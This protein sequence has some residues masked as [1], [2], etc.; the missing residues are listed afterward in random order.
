MNTMGVKM[1]RER[2]LLNKMPMPGLLL[3]AALLV[4]GPVFAG[5]VYVDAA[6]SSQDPDGSL[7]DP[8]PTIQEGINNADFYGHGRVEVPS[9]TARPGGSRPSCSSTPRTTR[10]F[11][12]SR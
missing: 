5:T 10:A 1:K 3:I 12:A 9:S 11:P 4:S 7:S 8:F 2:M 6:S